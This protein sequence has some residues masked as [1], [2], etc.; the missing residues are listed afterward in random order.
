MT[1]D[2]SS[3]AD[4]TMKNN[5][6]RL[7][8]STLALLTIGAPLLC[9][10]TTTFKPVAQFSYPG[11]YTTQANGIDDAGN[12]VGIFA[13]VGDDYASGFERF[14]NGTL[15]APIVF[16]GS[17]VYNTTPTSINNQGT[18]AGTYATD[19]PSGVHGFFLTNGIFTTFDYPGAYFTIIQGINDAGDFVGFYMPPD[20]SRHAFTSIGG[21]LSEITIP[22]ATYILPSDINNQDNIVGWYNTTEATHAF[23]LRA[24]GT[25]RTVPQQRNTGLQYLGTN[26]HGTSVGAFI[27]GAA[28]GGLYAPAK[29]SFVTYNYP[30]L[31]FNNFTSINR[32]GLICG[33]GYDGVARVTTSYILRAVVGG[34]AP[35]L[36]DR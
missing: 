27:G 4:R 20:N 18:I 7:A 5:P 3:G 8:F 16:P 19:I 32:R 2:P 31:T 36:G 21:Q 17:G 28:S 24:D 1:R 10:Q 15:S 33:F 35:S 12:I 34:A 25:L 22:D 11:A 26:D 29:G 6:F 14:A 23:R 9:A 13:L 30:G